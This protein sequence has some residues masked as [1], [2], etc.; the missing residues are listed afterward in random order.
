MVA[1]S[2]HTGFMALLTLVLI[3]FVASGAVQEEQRQ[4]AG[5]LLEP[6]DELQ[7]EGWLFHLGL[8]LTPSLAA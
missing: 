8:T 7:V 2:H 3:T 5:S 4:L 1:R 6:M